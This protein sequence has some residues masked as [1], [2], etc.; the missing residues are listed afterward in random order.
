M[1][2][3]QHFSRQVNTQ[4]RRRETPEERSKRLGLDDA[5]LG[6]RAST[7]GARRAGRGETRSGAIAVFRL[8]ILSFK[9]VFHFIYCHLRVFFTLYIVIYG[10]FS[11]YIVI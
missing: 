5:R 11:L 1:Q 4:L 2:R 9:G 6:G 3:G 7:A 10:C 8:Y